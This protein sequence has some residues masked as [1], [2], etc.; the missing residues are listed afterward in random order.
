M[1]FALYLLGFVVLIGGIAWGLV[2][3][4]VPHT[5]VAIA[6]VILVGIGIISGVARTRSKDPSS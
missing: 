1:S 6:C 4:G 2:L 3:A 5:Y